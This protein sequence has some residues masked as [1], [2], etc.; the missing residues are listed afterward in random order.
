MYCLSV[1]QAM[2]NRP[3]KIRDNFNREAS[4]IKSR[5]GFV[6][7]S[8]VFRSTA[9][10]GPDCCT[11]QDAQE[12][13]LRPGPAQWAWVD[14]I[15]GGASQEAANAAALAV[16]FGFP[17]AARFAPD[18]GGMHFE[19]YQAEIPSGAMVEYDCKFTLQE[20]FIA[21]SKRKH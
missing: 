16:Y 3:I 5:G 2:N 4:M 12:W 18:K 1:I 9:F 17:V 11:Y 21:W 14:Q 10:V 8:G 20:C 15:V 13:I 7:H 6:L 19:A